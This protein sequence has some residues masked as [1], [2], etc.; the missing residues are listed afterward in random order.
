MI[1]VDKQVPKGFEQKN[2]D[3][4]SLEFSKVMYINVVSDV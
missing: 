3:I 2:H 4:G 1:T